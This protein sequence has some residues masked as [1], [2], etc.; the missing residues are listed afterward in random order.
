MI[1]KLSY[2]QYELERLVLPDRI[3][4]CRSVLAGYYNERDKPLYYCK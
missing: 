1:Y 4:V 3:Q 2:R